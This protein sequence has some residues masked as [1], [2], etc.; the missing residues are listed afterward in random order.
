[1]DN[2]TCIV[3]DKKNNAKVPIIK[4]LQKF[5]TKGN[6][7]KNIFSQYN[8]NNFNLNNK[9]V[10]LEKNNSKRTI[11]KIKQIII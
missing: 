10:S 1:M 3:N 11:T 4:S 8:L 6:A 5:N 9:K 2:K 7:F